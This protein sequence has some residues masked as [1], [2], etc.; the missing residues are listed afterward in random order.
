M[1]YNFDFPD[2]TPLI[3]QAPWGNWYHPH[4]EQISRPW[5]HTTSGCGVIT[6]P[7][8]RIYYNDNMRVIAAVDNK[9]YEMML[10]YDKGGEMKPQLN[11]KACKNIADTLYVMLVEDIWIV[12][13]EQFCFS[14]FGKQIPSNI[15]VSF[16]SLDVGIH[17]E[18]YGWDWSS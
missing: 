18:D 9:H 4:I 6:G 1:K 12:N 15:E 17:K 10:E 7:L 11:H 14:E 16:F 8:V 13:D 2:V 5:D 3:I